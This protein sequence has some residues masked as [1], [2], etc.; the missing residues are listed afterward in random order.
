MDNRS[1]LSNIAMTN[2]YVKIFP[3]KR[4]Y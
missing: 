1:G 2:F 4:V 3:K